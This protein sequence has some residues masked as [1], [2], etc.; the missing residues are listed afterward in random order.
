[1]NNWQSISY[2]L[3]SIS[4]C[5]SLVGCWV[6]DAPTLVT[7]NT[8]DRLTEKYSPSDEFFLQRSFPDV[9][10]DINAYTKALQAV[11]E[12][13]V[14]RNNGFENFDKEWTVEGPGNLGARINTVAYHPDNTDIILA[15]FS[16]GGIFKTTDGGQNWKPVFDEQLF[17]A[18]GAISFDPQQ[19]NVVY[20]GTGDPNISGFPFIGDGIYKSTDTG[21]TWT[22]IG[23]RETRIISRIVVH[24]TNS[25]I[26]YVATM[27]LP[28]LPNTD[29]GLYKTIDGGETWEQVLFLGEETG[30]IDL[31]L[32]AQ[33]PEFIYA[34]G[35]DRLRNSKFSQTAGFGAKIHR[36]TDGGQTWQALRHILPQGKQSR[37]G[38]ATSQ[39]AVF[40]IYIDS[41]HNFN[42]V[43]RSFDH[44]STWE[45]V[46]TDLSVANSLRGFGWYFGQIRV[47]PL[48][49]NDITVLGVT[50]YRT[51]NGG[52]N[53]EVLSR[54]ANI[55]IH[56]DHHDLV[57]HPSGKMLVATDGGLYESKD[58]GIEWADIED[59][60]A[61]QTYRV[62]FNP[63]LPESYYGGF[64]D[65]GSAEGN[66]S[67]INEW[68]IYRGSDGFQT[69]F[70]PTEPDIFYAESQRGNIQVTQDGGVSWR[71]AT[72][73]IIPGDRRGW[74]MPYIMSTHN[75]SVLYTGT[76]RVYKSTAGT[77]PN[78][79]PISDDL[80]DGEIYERP[81]SIS[82]LSLSP[83]NKS[84]LYIGTMD[85]NVWRTSNDGD[86]WESIQGILP[87]RAVTDIV[88]SPDNEAVV[89]V[90][91]SGYKDNENTPRIYRSSNRGD[92]WQNIA[93]D[94]PQLAI[95]AIVV[96][97]GYNNQ[98]VF[99]ATDGG[100]YGTLDGGIHWER[101]GTNMPIVAAYD[102][103][104]NT[105]INTLSVGTFARSILS[106]PLE[107]IV[108]PPNNTLS[109]VS[110]LPSEDQALL[111]FP[112]PVKELLNLSFFN[113]AGSE[114]VN[115]SIFDINGQEVLRFNSFVN[116]EAFIQ[117]QVG[118][119]ETGIYILKIGD[120]FSTRSVQFVK[121]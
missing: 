101:L 48:D 92:S 8:R 38:L 64:Q 79:Q 73:G 9:A 36:S 42:G 91:Y 55:G 16:S 88:A 117:K 81:Q 51:K 66:A 46:P 107:G 18:I 76:H 3:L 118:T 47:N 40:S 14:S 4:I 27:G 106:Y 113:P 109:S 110:T 30:I 75:P 13:A 116:Q 105:G 28:F 17:L 37:I 65:N 90:S 53:W 119:L 33:N 45:E 10:F 11:K 97:Q 71:G 43:Y 56:V 84:L 74:D 102:L 31:V 87:E 62:A 25:D 58:N 63:H 26:L 104:W 68:E 32:D 82:T 61:S 44:G 59:I 22:Y 108:E 57:Y 77:V 99:V 19:P 111:L 50:T 115:I 1:M 67:S 120:S 78:W 86:T 35:W 12:R 41:L 5:L 2:L 54:N 6:S 94:L 83:I 49:K 21:E 69:V 112:N 96:P 100:V 95:N 93:G 39:D 98:V 121:M 15:G 60:P 80:T 23:L 70:H 89:F 103:V 114:L 72:D 29:K 20:A 24:P 34:A 52:S 85:A 7:D